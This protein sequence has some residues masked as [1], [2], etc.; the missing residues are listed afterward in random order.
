MSD[1]FPATAAP[2]MFEYVDRGDTAMP[3]DYLPQAPGVMFANED[4]LNGAG[5]LPGS[6]RP[7]GWLKNQP[8]NYTK[9]VGKHVLQVRQCGDSRSVHWTVERFEFWDFKW[10]E[11]LVFPFGHV[12]IWARTRQAAIRLAEHC[13]PVPCLPIA[14]RWE[15]A[16]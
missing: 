13:Y 8:G 5:Y 11:A 6:S 14:G 2:L 12:P 9:R 4:I 16:R 15:V 7:K 1:L 3:A 10:I